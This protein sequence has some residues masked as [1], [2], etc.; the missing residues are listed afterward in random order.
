MHDKSQVYLLTNQIPI[1]AL[2]KTFL[3][4]DKRQAQN[5]LNAEWKSLVLKPLQ[6]NFNICL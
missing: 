5:L 6:Y 1:P 3:K 2:D 4:G